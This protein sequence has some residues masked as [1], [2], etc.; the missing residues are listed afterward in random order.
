MFES[1]SVS[2]SVMLP[3]LFKVTK[4]SLPC[5]SSNVAVLSATSG[6]R[7]AICAK[8]PT[9]AQTASGLETISILLSILRGVA[10]SVLA[11]GGASAEKIMRHRRTA[12]RRRMIKDYATRPAA[13]TSVGVGSSAVH[14]LYRTENQF[15]SWQ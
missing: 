6:F 4:R 8:S 12:K 11:A 2:A 5:V 10:P 9:M 3:P 7:T 1:Y 14:V 13:S 15:Q